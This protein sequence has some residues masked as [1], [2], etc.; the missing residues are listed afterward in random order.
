VRGVSGGARVT[1]RWARG[2]RTVRDAGRARQ[3]RH[4]PA[5]RFPR[6]DRPANRRGVSPFHPASGAASGEA[7]G[8]GCATSVVASGLEVTEAAGAAAEWRQAARALLPQ[9]GVAGSG[10]GG[11]GARRVRAVMA[12][13]GNCAGSARINATQ[14]TAV[15]VS[16]EF[17]F[18]FTRPRV[19]G[20]GPLGLV[21]GN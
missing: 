14:E 7:S 8:A 20:K 12:G 10:C 9:A 11:G 18:S 21:H 13:Y 15:K 16:L 19:F 3:E 17:A 2:A 6:G 4:L 1:A 5:R